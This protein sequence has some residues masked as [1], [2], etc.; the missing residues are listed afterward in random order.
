[1]PGKALCRWVGWYVA[2]LA[3]ASLGCAGAPVSN[4]PRPAPNSCVI[5]HATGEPV[6]SLTVALPAHAVTG[7]NEDP[8]TRL[9]DG[10]RFEPL[11]RVDCNGVMIPAL[12]ES[13]QAASTGRTWTFTIREGAQ[14]PDGIPVTVRDVVAS[15]RTSAPASRGELGRFV[16]DS[17]RILGA[18]TIAVTLPDTSVR[19]LSDPAF[20]LRVAAG[21]G[22]EP[23]GTG[24]Y[25]LVADSGG[26]RLHPGARFA[27]APHIRLARSTPGMGPRDM[28]DA[29]VDL[30]VTE[31]PAVMRYAIAHPELDAVP[32]PLGRVYVLVT[33]ADSSGIDEGSLPAASLREELARDVVPARARAAEARYWWNDLPV[34]A[35]A[36][37]QRD[38]E[39]V[40]AASRIVY[41]LRD[42]VAGALAQRLIAL[43]TGATTRDAAALEVLTQG[44]RAAAATPV[45]VGLPTEQFLE[46]LKA[47]NEVAH[48]V[49]LPVR[50]FD[51][52]LA[53]GVLGDAL[54]S[55][56]AAMRL[57][58]LIEAGGWA[59]VRRG[60]VTLELDRDGSIHFGPGKGNEPG[61]SR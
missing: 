4:E 17:A 6:E 37:S 20:S 35:P 50:P 41:D 34:C 38:S 13:W 36:E 51:R 11:F 16:A 48:V 58:P 55:G 40:R 43:A 60:R 46:S 28:L 47:A 59:V 30:L 10:L 44:L 9:I 24:P 18:R 7:W 22:V 61:G 3:M 1:M 14:L 29:G 12:A 19:L 8:I 42:P 52:C 27:N 49:S 39:P 31:D 33:A 26:L 2:A 32:L 23:L 21:A 57:T 56:A 53:I 5:A 54:A 15:W 45:A 25:E